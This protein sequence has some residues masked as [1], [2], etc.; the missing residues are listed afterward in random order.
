M[1]SYDQDVL[2]FKMH[3]LQAEIAMNSMIAENKR[4]EISGEPIAYVEKDFMDLINRY[5]IYDNAFPAYK[6]Y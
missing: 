2:E 3:L 4:R 6:G 1:S 5:G